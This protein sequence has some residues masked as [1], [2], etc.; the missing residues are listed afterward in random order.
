MISLLLNLPTVSTRCSVSGPV[1]LLLILTSL[2]SGLV[3]FLIG[4]IGSRAALQNHV[5]RYNI[6]NDSTKYI[7]FFS[8]FCGGFC[9]PG[10]IPSYL[11]KDE[12][13]VVCG[14]KATGYHYRCITCEGCKVTSVAHLVR[15]F[16]S[17]YVCF[18]PEH[19]QYLLTGVLQADHPEEPE[20][21]LRL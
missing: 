16:A 9:V 20:S 3:L 2:N 10:Y 15:T 17:V 6:R 12:L 7:Y 13:C 21:H 4:K 14:D 1:L 8:V 5:F 19:Y 18:F 11:D